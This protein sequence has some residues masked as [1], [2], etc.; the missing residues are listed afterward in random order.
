[1]DEIFI[2]TIKQTATQNNFRI[3]HYTYSI[4]GIDLSYIF[5]IIEISD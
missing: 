5:Y 1:M 4:C 2:H 3:E